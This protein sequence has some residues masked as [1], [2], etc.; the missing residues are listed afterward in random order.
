LNG[1]CRMPFDD[2]A[3]DVAVGEEQSG[4]EAI[5]TSADDED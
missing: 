2:D 3:R 1:C 5:Q 4:G